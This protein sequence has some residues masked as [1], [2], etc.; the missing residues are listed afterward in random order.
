MLAVLAAVMIGFSLHSTLHVQPSLIA[1]L[2]AGAIVLV[3][4]PRRLLRRQLPG[5]SLVVAATG[6]TPQSVV[7]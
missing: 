7:R 1:L 3:S 2:G 5:E 4:T 6:S